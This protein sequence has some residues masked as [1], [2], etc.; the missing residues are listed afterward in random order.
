MHDAERIG[1]F[2]RFAALVADLD[3]L[4][5]IE[6]RR[7]LA[8]LGERG[9]VDHLHHEVAQRI[10]GAHVLEA[11]VENA[12]DVRMAQLAGERRLVLEEAQLAPCILGIGGELLQHLD[13]DLA[14][15]ERIDR[16][17]D[18]AGRTLAEQLL[19]LV[20]ADVRKHFSLWGRCARSHRTG[21]A[22]GCASRR[23]GLNC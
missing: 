19:H 15:A 2:Q 13:R 22:F 14:L 23:A 12:D 9:A 18:R 8:V 11:R 6:Q 20:L 10:A 4:Q 1:E 5:G 17:I 21:R 16:E 3:R 7:R